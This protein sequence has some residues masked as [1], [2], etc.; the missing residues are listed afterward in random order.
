[1]SIVNTS[2]Q[3]LILSI[4]IA[5]HGP[6]LHRRCRLILNLKPHRLSF[7]LPNLLE[8]A[9]KLDLLPIAHILLKQCKVDA[10]ELLNKAYQEGHKE[11]VKLIQKHMTSLSLKVTGI[12][13]MV[14]GTGI[15]VASISLA[16][17]VPP[18]ALS[19]LI[20]LGIGIVLFQVGMV[21]LA[22]NYQKIQ[23]SETPPEPSLVGAR[24]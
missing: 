21:A 9:Y 7:S 2:F 14:I 11:W 3:F 6:W 15:C 23:P 19:G 1:M 22:A 5:Y 16:C 13:S 20:M 10:K 18:M 17:L 8:C 24:A 12:A 4:F